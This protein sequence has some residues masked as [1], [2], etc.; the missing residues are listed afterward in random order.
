MDKITYGTFE[1]DPAALPAKSLEAMIRRGITHFMGNEQAAKVSG[2][3]AKTLA[4][5]KVEAT[6]EQIAAVKADFQQKAYAALMAGE[7]GMRAAGM[8]KVD[9][10]E[11]A[12][13]R[14][15]KVAVTTLLKANGFKIPKGEE[16][17]Q[18]GSDVLTMEEMIE[19]WLAKEANADAAKKQAEK[20]IKD[21]AK[22]HANAKVEGGVKSAAD[23]F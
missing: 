22:R 1:I 16:T 8:P 15:A 6:D 11:A 23:L 21:K 19:R 2:F 17:I 20:E 5:T 18:M 13:D 10:V 7:V 9:P 14:I 12:M 4:D 3:K